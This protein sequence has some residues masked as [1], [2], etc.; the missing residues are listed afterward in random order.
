MFGIFEKYFFGK[1]K[2]LARIHVLK[3]L[4]ISQKNYGRLNLE[5]NLNMQEMCFKLRLRLLNLKPRK[6]N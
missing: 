4:E 1:L 5:G 2:E 3:F 6:K